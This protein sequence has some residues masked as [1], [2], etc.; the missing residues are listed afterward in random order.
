MRPLITLSLTA[1]LAACPGPTNDT[2]DTDTPWVCEISDGNAPN[3]APRL[4]CP[5]DFESLAAAPFDSSI[6][7]A[8]S[9]KTLVD[10]SDSDRL[11]FMNSNRFPIHWDF[12]SATLSGGGLPFVPELSTFNQTEYTSPDRRFVLG[13]VTYYS[14]PDV[15]TYELAP[16]DTASAEMIEGAFDAIRD[17]AWMGSDLML[18]PSS[19]TVMRN[20]VDLPDDIPIITTDELFTGIDFQPLN[21]GETVA[22]VSF[23]R[24]ADVDESFVNPRAL[25]VLDAIPNDISVVAGI[26]TAAFQTPLSHINVLSQNRGT[27]NMAL[28]GA[29]DNE[30]LRGLD[31]AWVRLTVTANDWT[32]EEV[33]LAEADTWWEEN[34]PE[35]IDIGEMDLMVTAIT[36]DVDLLNLEGQSLSAAL[37]EAVPAFGGKAAHY[38]GL[39]LIGDAVPS[40]PG[41]AI[42]VYYYNQHMETH[43]LWARVDEMLA[44]EAFRSDPLVRS[45]ELQ[46]LRDAIKAAPI[47]PDLLADVSTKILEGPY[48]TTRMRFR[49]STNAEDLGTFTG[50]GLYTS[51]TGDPTDPDKPVDE[52]MKKVWASVWG[53][54]AYEE[55]DY[56]GID[57]KAVG[58]A[59]LSHRSFPD[60]EA[61]GVAIT[62]NLFD[63]SGVESAFY[64]NVQ[65]GEESVV[66]PDAGVISDQFLYY[67]DLP[68]Q[69][70]VYLAHSSLVPEGE[71]VLSDAQAFELGGALR[72]VH[73]Y[74]APAYGSAPFYAMDTEFKFDDDGLNQEPILYLKQARPYPGRGE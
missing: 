11:Y 44:D 56:W 4:G 32:V 35:P 67:F 66:Q 41:F 16:Y 26:I 21:L 45:V 7:G 46:A 31:G 8:R 10:R 38:G 50:A 64:V 60:E 14:G 63:P 55:R 29:F 47:D 53:Q 39:S 72:A 15:W 33:T 28:R 70:I 17:N 13:A 57:H 25:V 36:D 9:A 43:N 18:H 42:P 71:T 68:G 61:N 34:R 24:A 6:P 52:A 3:S 54:R 62:A 65:D 22:Q 74:F 49:S 19:D 27:P 40:P 2:V 59:L 5:E 51:K 12:A 23:K 48:G 58:M 30:E 1:A 37:S 73:N 69:P 20:T